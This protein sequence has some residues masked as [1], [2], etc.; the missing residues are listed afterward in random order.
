MTEPITSQQL[1]E[2]ETRAAHLHEYAILTNE[3]SQADADQLTGKDVPLL[4]ADLRR[5]RDRVAEL[6]AFAYGCDAEGCVLPH[7]SWCDAA[8][9]TAAANN[10]CTCGR[11]WT[12]HPQP[13]A[14]HCWTVNP[15]RAEVEEMR[16]RIAELSAAVAPDATPE[17]TGAPVRA[18]Q[19]SSVS[20]SAQSPTGAATGRLGDPAAP[21]R[22]YERM[23]IARA[24]LEKGFTDREW[25]AG[26]IVC[27][28]GFSCVSHPL[29]LFK[30]TKRGRLPVHRHE[31]LGTPCPGSGQ[32]PT[33]PP[34][35]LRKPATGPAEDP[36]PADEFTGTQPC[37]HDDY[38]DPHPWA[39]RPGV[40]CP[41]IG[42]D[43]EAAEETHIVA[44][45]SSDPAPSDDHDL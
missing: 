1:D 15:P 33:T 31:T 39:D 3:L 14:M 4:V 42:Y 27:P 40:W 24:G 41:G 9:K 32:K 36:T 38:H 22:N 44:D 35:K 28:E 26:R 18:S 43:D 30:P 5:T 19:P 2:I 11:P 8:K 37:G 6:E 12:G 13:H 17:A 7:S 20:E 45:D 34:L 23:E 16:K 21:S 25:A 10:G 29:A